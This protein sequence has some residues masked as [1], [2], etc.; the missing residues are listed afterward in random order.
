MQLT[1]RLFDGDGAPVPD[2]MIEL[3]DAEGQHW[4]EPAQTRTEPFPS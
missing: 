1:G 4:A 3:W 2:G